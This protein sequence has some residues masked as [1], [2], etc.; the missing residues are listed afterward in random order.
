MEYAILILEAM[1]TYLVRNGI[2]DI[3]RDVFVHTMPAH[4]LEGVLFLPPDS[5]FIKDLELVDYYRDICKLVIR[6]NSI[7]KGTRLMREILTILEFNS[8]TVGDVHFNFVRSLTL[9]LPYIRDE[10][11]GYEVSVVLEFSCYETI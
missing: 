3:G 4:C 8:Q 2:G 10:S 7:T 6:C 1:A 5:G 9:P 11:G